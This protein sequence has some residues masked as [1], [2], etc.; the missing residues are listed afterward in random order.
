[1]KKYFLIA[2]S[3]MLATTLSISFIACDFGDDDDDDP[4]EIDLN[5]I[6]GVDAK[7]VGTWYNGVSEGWDYADGVLVNHWK[8]ID[9][10][11]KRSFHIFKGQEDGTYSDNTT[12]P[13]WQ[14]LQLDA[15]GT[16][17]RSNEDGDDELSGRFAA[18]KGYF[19]AYFNGIL[20]VRQYRF[21]ETGQLML[22]TEKY[23]EDKELVGREIDYFEKVEDGIDP[24]VVGTWYNYIDDYKEY[25]NGVL[26]LH[27]EDLSDT[28]RCF[29]EVIDGK[30]TGEYSIEKRRE[31]TWGEI[32]FHG[33][34]T[35]TEEGQLTESTP[36]ENLE[37]Y[38]GTFTT[39]NNT[40]TITEG[41]DVYQVSYLFDKDMLLIFGEHIDGDWTSKSIS[42]Y[43]RG[44][45]PYK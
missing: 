6:I 43:E 10:T 3:L 25:Y 41:E 11:T 17:S 27:W 37:Y 28:E 8:D 13:E 31:L 16:F 35:W 24:R 9:E 7:I 34:G 22:I 2:M 21:S 15:N 18:D 38:S 30:E 44:G 39:S 1:M 40:M 36:K 14:L 29:F 32:V 12:E 33:D 19:V 42:Y 26:R 23:N 5:S 20:D 45:Y 4:I